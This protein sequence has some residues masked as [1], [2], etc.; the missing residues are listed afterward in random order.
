M[1][2]RS[3]LA[4][5]L[6][7]FLGNRQHCK[8]KGRLGNPR[9]RIRVRHQVINSLNRL[10]SHSCACSVELF[11]GGRAYFRTDANEGVQCGL[12]ELHAECVDC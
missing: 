12:S 11:F 3:V 6:C 10:R 9:R 8:L 2:F 4:Q 5:G 7:T 1:T